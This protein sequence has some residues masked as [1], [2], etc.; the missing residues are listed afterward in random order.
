MPTSALL[1]GI[2]NCETADG[3]GLASRKCDKDER[4]TLR[5]DQI[6]RVW[7]YAQGVATAAFCALIA[8][9]VLRLTGSYMTWAMASGLALTLSAEFELLTAASSPSVDQDHSRLFTNATRQSLNQW[10]VK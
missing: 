10:K 2:N 1:G 4:S 3:T 9:W 6:A 7:E 8:L 5:D